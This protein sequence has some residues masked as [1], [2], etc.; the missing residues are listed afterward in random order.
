MIDYGRKLCYFC[1]K[2]IC[3]PKGIIVESLILFVTALFIG[4]EWLSLVT[5]LNTGLSRYFY[6][7]ILLKIA[8][9]FYY[10]FFEV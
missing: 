9:L 6:S 4:E 3:G 10:F 7:E 8:R 2:G 5:L 1:F